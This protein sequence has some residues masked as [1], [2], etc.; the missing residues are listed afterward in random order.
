MLSNIISHTPVYVWAILAFLVFR[1]VL[2]LREREVSLPRL[3]IIPA[4]M[5]V[6]ALQSIA[7][8]YGLAS[9]AMAAWLLATAAMAL[10]RWTFGASRIQ[11]GAEPGTL[12]M[13]G[14]WAPLLLMLAVFVIK[15]ALAVVQAVRPQLAQGAGFA[16]TACC[17]LGLCNGVFIGQLARD[18]AAARRLGAGQPSAKA[19]TPVT[20]P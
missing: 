18:V 8:R 14:S 3:T 2:A 17:L 10:Q 7:S 12:R 20:M 19:A 6:L 4:V 15:Y 13:G 11:A 9:L 5:L 1:G 16:M